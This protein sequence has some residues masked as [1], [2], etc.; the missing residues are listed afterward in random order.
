MG[1]AAPASLGRMQPY[2]GEYTSCDE[3]AE[4]MEYVNRFQATVAANTDYSRGKGI[5]TAVLLG[6]N[7]E[8]G[9]MMEQQA[10][11]KSGVTRRMA[12]DNEWAEAQ[13]EDDAPAYEG[14]PPCKSSW[15]S[16]NYQRGAGNEKLCVS[17][18]RKEREKYG[19]GK[20]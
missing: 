2:L 16:W 4:G 20:S 17:F 8:R 1:C 10:A 13:C 5:A 3:I 12:L 15:A 19:I 14:P 7:T 6:V 9:D 11:W 18:S